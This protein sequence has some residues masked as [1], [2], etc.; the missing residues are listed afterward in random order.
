MAGSDGV[1]EPEAQPG[2]DRPRPAAHP[3]EHGVSETDAMPAADGA[4]PSQ[5][6][7]VDHLSGSSVSQAEAQ[8]GVDD[9]G[10]YAPHPGEHGASEGETN[11]HP[12]D[13]TEIF[14][15]FTWGGF[16]KR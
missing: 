1:S 10:E 5:H 16:G 3:G 2:A 14:F 4:G 12:I 6:L 15:T 7:H 9:E 13:D 8:P 11:I